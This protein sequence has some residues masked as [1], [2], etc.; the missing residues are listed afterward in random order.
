MK[1]NTNIFITCNYNKKTDYKNMDNKICQKIDKELDKKN[2]ILDMNILKTL[3][4]HSDVILRYCAS[5]NSI[6]RNALKYGILYLHLN[7]N[8]YKYYPYWYIICKNKNINY[9]QRIIERDILLSHL[10]KPKIIYN[11]TE[12]KNYYKDEKFND[13]KSTLDF[14]E[15]KYDCDNINDYNNEYSDGSSSEYD[16]YKQDYY[17]MYDYTSSDNLSE[18][19]EDIDIEIENKSST[20]TTVVD[21]DEDN[22]NV[23]NG[24]LHYKY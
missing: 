10:I 9:K 1:P 12:Y 20:I 18:Q 13:L 23:Y 14:D 6:P 24:D 21:D 8:N 17:E 4:D 5:R 3:N 15:S 2:Y 11:P 7:I 19:I 22:D 16:D